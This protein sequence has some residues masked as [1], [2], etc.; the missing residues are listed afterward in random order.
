[1]INGKKLRSVVDERGRV[2]IP[3]KVRESAGISSGTIVQ[4]QQKGKIVEV[5]PT[6]EKRR[7]WRDLSGLEPKRTGRPSWPTP[8]EIKSIWE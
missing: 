8:E 4:M 2:L 1:M 7:T 6:S 3:Q 5:I